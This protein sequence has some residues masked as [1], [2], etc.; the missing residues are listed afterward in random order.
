MTG[1]RDDQYS[2]DARI[3]R[4]YHGA[5]TYFATEIIA[6][7]NYQLT[8]AQLWDQLVVRLQQDGLRPGAAGRGQEREQG[9]IGLHMSERVFER[10]NQQ[11]SSSVHWCTVAG[12][13]H[14]T[15]MNMHQ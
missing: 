4:R 14:A 10:A 3:G 15:Q 1:C 11:A 2:Y 8:Y 6:E 7:A 13:R 12:F 5:M 9:P